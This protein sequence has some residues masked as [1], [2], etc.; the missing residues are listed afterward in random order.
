MEELFQEELREHLLDK[1][2][3]ELTMNECIHEVMEVFLRPE[4]GG[5][6]VENLNQ[7]VPKMTKTGNL[8]CK[9][10]IEKV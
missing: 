8:M 4:L 1:D 6:I 10:F 2:T 7:N 3:V 9:E 5:I